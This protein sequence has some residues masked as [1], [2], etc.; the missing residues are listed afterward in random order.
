[1]PKS[2]LFLE[3]KMVGID[4]PRNIFVLLTDYLFMTFRLLVLTLSEG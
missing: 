2:N 3:N 4:L 1:M